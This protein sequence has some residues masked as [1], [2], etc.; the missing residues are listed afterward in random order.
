MADLEIEFGSPSIFGTIAGF[1]PNDASGISANWDRAV[2]YGQMG[3]EAASKLY[4]AIYERN[5]TFKNASATT[6]GTVPPTIGALLGDALLTSIEIR[7]TATDFPTMALTG[8]QHPSH[9]H[10]N[11]RRQAAHGIALTVAFGA[12]NFLGDDSGLELQSSTCRIVVDHVDEPGQT[13]DHAAGQNYNGRIEL[14][15]EYLGMYADEGDFEST[16]W[17][18]QSIV[19]GKTPQGFAKTTVTAIKPLTLSTPSPTT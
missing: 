10:A 7:T 18:I 12:Q 2:A 3:D 5:Q 9:P 19:P 13:G 14:T 6:P 4:N 17:D 11:D 15:Q 8:H 1:V 16:G